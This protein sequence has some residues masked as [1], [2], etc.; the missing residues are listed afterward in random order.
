MS[1][2]NFKDKDST[3]ENYQDAYRCIN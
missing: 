3:R 2:Q 1:A